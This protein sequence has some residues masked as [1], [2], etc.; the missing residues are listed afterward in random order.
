MT[1]LISIEYRT[2][3]G[4][5]LVLR[6]GK[7]RIALQYADGGV[8]TC[9]VERYA[10]ARS[11][12]NTVTKSSARACASAANGGRTRCGS[13]PGRGCVRCAFA[14]A[15]R[16]CPPTRR[17]T[18]RHSPG[19]SSAAGKPVIRRKQPATS[20][21]ASSCPPCGRTKRSPSPAAAVNWATGNESSRWTTA[22]SRNGNSRYIPHTG[23]NTNS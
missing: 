21:C 22:A 12:Q 3:W 14:T 13:R 7:R 19:A 18:P 11:R 2:R 4:E 6:L 10:P 9:A 23:S 8:C 5:Q 17:S 16:R 20:P 1:L 15:G